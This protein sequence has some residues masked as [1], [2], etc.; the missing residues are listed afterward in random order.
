MKEVKKPSLYLNKKLLS[1]RPKKELQALWR[2]ASE[3]MG[4]WSDFLSKIEQEIKRRK[5]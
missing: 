4:M 5:K 3:E 1:E 2:W